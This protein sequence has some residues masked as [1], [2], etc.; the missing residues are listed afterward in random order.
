MARPI[1]A[2]NVPITIEIFAGRAKQIYAAAVANPSGTR[3]RRAILLQLG[4]RVLQQASSGGDNFL[5]SDLKKAG[6]GRAHVRKRGAARRIAQYSIA[7]CVGT[8]AGGIGGAEDRN[9]WDV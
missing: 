9:H 2:T 3:T 8:V 6:I 7:S 4:T 5:S 1:R